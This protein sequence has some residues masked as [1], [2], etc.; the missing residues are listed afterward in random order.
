VIKYVT[1]K[2]IALD[3]LSPFPGNAN[4]GDV[5]KILES[6]RANGQYRSLI[7]RHT[8]H[9]NV[10]LAG[11]HTM[12]ALAEHGTGKCEYD[13]E[14]T[15]CGVC[16]QGWTGRP[17]CEVYT[18]DDATALRVNIADNRIPEFSHRDDQLTAALLAELDDLTGTGYTFEE[19]TELGTDHVEKMPEPGDADTDD[20]MRVWGVIVT[21]QDEASQVELLTEL[22][23]KGHDVKAM[24]L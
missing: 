5:P 21:C 13:S 16:H 23:D 20:V 2:A 10:V 17:R 19:F 4:V 3:Q 6:L 9:G 18:C 24:M 7:V 15:P 11:N 22:A 1:T 14:Q 12:A 8:E